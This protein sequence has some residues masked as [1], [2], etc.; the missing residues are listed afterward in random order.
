MILLFNT[1]E[2][3]NGD[4][5]GSIYFLGYVMYMRLYMLHPKEQATPHF[6][7]Q[8]FYLVNIVIS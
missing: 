8:H 2:K 7:F 5:S 6:L 4:L 1:S 3:I